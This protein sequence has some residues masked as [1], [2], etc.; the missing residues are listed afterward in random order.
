[1][2]GCGK[3]L[4]RTDNLGKHVRAVHGG[5]DTGAVLRRAGARKRR[6]YAEDEE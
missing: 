5:D 4:S 3:I 6:R 1:M 2:S